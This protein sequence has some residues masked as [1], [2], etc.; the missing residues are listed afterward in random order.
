MSQI[1]FHGTKAIG[2]IEVLLYFSVLQPSTLLHINFFILLNFTEIEMEQDESLSASPRPMKKTIN[3]KLKSN[4]SPSS[5]RRK[6]RSTKASK[7]GENEPS[8]TGA[9]FIQLY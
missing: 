2:A 6:T 5:S 1:Y 8:Q 9:I 4:K 3:I 7:K